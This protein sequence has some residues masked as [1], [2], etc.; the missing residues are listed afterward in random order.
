MALIIIS[1]SL[2]PFQIIFST[3]KP[4]LFLFFWPNNSHGFQAPKV[5]VFPGGD[6]G[7]LSR[8]GEDLLGREWWRP[9]A[10]LRRSGRRSS[11][12]VVAKGDGDGE[13]RRKM[14]EFLGSWSSLEAEKP[15]HLPWLTKFANDLP[16]FNHYR[17]K[18]MVDVPWFNHDQN[19]SLKI[20]D[21]QVQVF[22]FLWLF[23]GSSSDWLRWGCIS[24][25]HDDIGDSFSSSI[26]RWLNLH[27]WWSNMMLS[28]VV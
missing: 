10:I 2:L 13:R 6:Q 12:V 16:W 27:C 8:H 7:G 3:L 15:W 17:S 28:M 4:L 20:A 9:T 22:K 23:L 14:I 21:V 11:S 24:S 5:R 19:P 25:D 26:I 1:A 18:K